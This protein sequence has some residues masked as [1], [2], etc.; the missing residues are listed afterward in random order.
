MPHLRKYH[1]GIL[2]LHNFLRI[3]TKRIWQK[4]LVAGPMSLVYFYFYLVIKTDF[5]WSGNKLA[6]IWIFRPPLQ[7]DVAVLDYLTWKQTLLGRSSENY[8]S[9]T[10]NWYW[11]IFPLFPDF[12]FLLDFG[13]MAGSLATMLG[14]RQ[15]PVLVLSMVGRTKRRILVPDNV[16]QPLCRIK[17][18]LLRALYKWEGTFLY[19][20]K[21]SHVPRCPPGEASLHD[22]RTLVYPMGGSTQ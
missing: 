19:L 6:E 9:E 13:Q 16:V 22:V 4:P 7:I 12:C 10:E 2:A 21:C 11:S 3:F 5:I 1:V 18:C 20:S 14:K 15:P 8:N 17:H